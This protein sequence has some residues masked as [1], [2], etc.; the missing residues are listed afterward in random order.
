[1]NKK[2]VMILFLAF[3]FLPR[4]LQAEVVSHEELIVGT[5]EAPPFSIQKEDGSWT[6]LSIDLW[7]LIAKDLGI[8]YQLKA[9]DLNNLVRQLETGEIDAAVAALTITPEREK[10]FDFSHP[11][12]ID[13]L[14]IAV[15][16]PGQQNMWSAVRGIFTLQFFQAVGALFLILLLFG[17]L[18]W[19]F[20]R[21]KN[22]EQFG[23]QGM[24][25]IGSGF[26]WSAVTM[27]TVGYGD[28]APKTFAGRLV[29][30]IWM[31]LAIIV[32]SSFTAAISSSLTVNQLETRIR[33]IEDLRK[34]KVAS[35]PGSTSETFLKKNAVPYRVYG[36]LRESLEDLT[37]GTIDAVVYDAPILNYMIKSEFQ[38]EAAMLPQVFEKQQYGIALKGGSA[39]REPLN[40][41][42]LKILASAEW[43][44][45]ARQYS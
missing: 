32:I 27:T 38:G 17:F 13:G 2:V 5:K 14:G 23:G 29:G 8:R 45:L 41:S 42:L 25:G 31:F 22:A 9:L 19:L 36:T 24:A 16:P 7:R 4:G 37:A 1:M 43:E 21:K 15:Q 33:G 44:T 28:K 40:Q 3:V 18:V 35:L 39:L 30:I 10:E 26:W 11:F 6:G 12:L 34:M 20:E